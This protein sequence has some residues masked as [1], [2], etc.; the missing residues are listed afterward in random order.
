MTERLAVPPR[1]LNLVLMSAVSW[2]QTYRPINRIGLLS[3][4]SLCCE[5]HDALVYEFPPL[6]YNESLYC[7]LGH[8]PL[9]PGWALSLGVKHSYSDDHWLGLLLLIL[10]P[11]ITTE[12]APW[13]PTT[14]RR[15]CGTDEMRCRQQRTE[16]YCKCRNAVRAGLLH[17]PHALVYSLQV[18]TTRKRNY[19]VHYSATHCD[20]CAMHIIG[21]QAIGL[22]ELSCNTFKV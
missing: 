1:Q 7:R 17:S 4:V 14:D 11:G 10:L 21:F 20:G 18:Y 13:G 8:A 22:Y 16:G 9:L 6:K 12:I 2:A 19:S 15:C 5:S 3:W